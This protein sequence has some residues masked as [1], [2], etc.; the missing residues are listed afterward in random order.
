MICLHVF[1]MSPPEV[2]CGP[3]LI[4]GAGLGIVIFNR[5]TCGLP[6]STCLI[7]AFSAGH[8]FF[9]LL[10]FEFLFMF[11]L[12]TVFTLVAPDFF[13]QYHH[14]QPSSQVFSFTFTYPGCTLSCLSATSVSFWTVLFHIYTCCSCT[15]CLLFRVI[16]LH[17]FSASK[18]QYYVV[19][20]LLFFVQP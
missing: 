4:S 18:S 17:L 8:C 9:L 13:H 3:R 1:P 20:N 7:P 11:L 12:R 16:F 19:I 5:H 2:A 10:S 6:I 14:L 15:L